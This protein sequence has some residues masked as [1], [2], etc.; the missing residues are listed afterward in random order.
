VGRPLKVIV[1]GSKASQDGNASP[2]RW[3]EGIKN[4]DFVG[5]DGNLMGIN[6]DLTGINGDLMGINGGLVGMCGLLVVISPDSH[7]IQWGNNGVLPNVQR[8]KITFLLI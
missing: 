5:I 4:G 2:R 1:S 6:G 7:E 3:G 8:W